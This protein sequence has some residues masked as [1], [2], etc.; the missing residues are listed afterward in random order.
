VATPLVDLHRHLEG[1]IRPE[2]CV[3]L[4]TRAGSVT[5]P[6]QWRRVTVEAIADAVSDGLAGLEL[7]FRRSSSPP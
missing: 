2:T 7:R 3:E 5:L 4:A 1:S 6:A